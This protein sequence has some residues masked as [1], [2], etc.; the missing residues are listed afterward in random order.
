MK[1]TLFILTALLFA[2]A[3]AQAQ[4]E[5]AK[6]AKSA[7]KAL[8][9]YN[10]DPSSNSAKL[11]EAKQK[12]DQAIQHP[13]FQTLASGWITRGD[14]YN[15]ILSR[16][17]ARRMID[18]KFVL[19][20]DNDALV[21]FEAY[22]KGYEVSTKKYEKSDAIKG[23]ADVQANLINIGATKYEAGEFE[24]SFLSFQ[25]SLQA[26]DLLKANN[27]KS[28]LDE[29]GKYDELS[30]YTATAAWE[31]KRCADAIPIFD[32]L[33]KNGTNEPAA[34][35]GL[36]ECK[37]QAGDTAA[38]QII[39]A[40]GRK[41]F[42]EDTR[43]LFAE[44]NAFRDAGKLDE[45]PGRLQK[46]I[47][48]EPDNVGLYTAMG[49]VYAELLARELE[50]KNETKAD[51]YF[52]QAEKYYSLATQKGPRD[53]DAT[54][55][56]GALYYN[57]AVALSQALDAMPLETSAAGQKKYAAAKE[58]VDA[59][60]EQSLPHLEKAES[61]DANNT[62]TLIALSTIYARKDDEA[63]MIEFS[64]RLETVRAGGKNASSHFKQ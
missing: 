50:A 51:E 64:K 29:K 18:P 24:K 61:L 19:S 32:N 53:V 55:L 38:A 54:Y 21:A 45:L 46:A 30:F 48:K 25:A 43:L 4:D 42:P 41:K 57:K 33:V 44:I 8:T 47:E 63:L 62:N 28:H 9:S 34:Y 11:E 3:I 22:K 49:N 40:D 60:F 56:L 15:T 16:D 2:G 5:G 14:I 10:I 20:G 7:G 26:H 36:Y 31:A 39:L 27:E 58:K 52:K 35:A 59:L 17:M 12:I 37:M 6:L 23:I 13:D 1:K